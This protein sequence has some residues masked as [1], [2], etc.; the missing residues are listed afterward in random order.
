[1]VSID[2]KP[3]VWKCFQC[4]WFKVIKVRLKRTLKKE[5]PGEAKTKKARRAN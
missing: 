5:L 3:W 2:G 1:M 4:G